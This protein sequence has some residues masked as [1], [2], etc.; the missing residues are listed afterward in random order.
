[1][2]NPILVDVDGV[3][4]DF[5][6]EVLDFI[7]NEHK[8]N[9]THQHVTEFHIQKCFSAYWNESTDKFINSSGF[10]SR[11]KILPGAQESIEELRKEGHKILF[12]TSP[13]AANPTWCYDRFEWLSKHFGVTW[14]DVIFAHQKCHV[15]GATL[16]DDRFKSIKEWSSFNKKTSILFEQPWNRFEQE[17]PWKVLLNGTKIVDDYSW[18][19]FNNWKHIVEY[20]KNGKVIK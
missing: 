7:N 6:S 5:V 15:Q 8:L 12:V 2:Q 20:I 14:K 19:S 16:I 11:L 13:L 18:V 3:L 10:A 17:S 4:A 1:M 9:L